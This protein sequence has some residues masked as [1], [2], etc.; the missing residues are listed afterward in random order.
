MIR[1]YMQICWRKWKLI[2]Y[3]KNEGDKRRP[4]RLSTACASKL[5]PNLRPNPLP[6]ALRGRKNP[7]S[8]LHF[9]KSLSPQSLSEGEIHFPPF[10]FLSFSPKPQTQIHTLSKKKPISWIW[11]KL[12]DCPPP[13]PPMHPQNDLRTKIRRELRAFPPGSG[14]PTVGGGVAWGT[15]WRRPTPATSACPWAAPPC[16]S[17]STR[18]WGTTLREPILVQSRWLRALRRSWLHRRIW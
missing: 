11:C 10:P 18:S 2:Y 8:P 6:P 3:N 13:A 14:E 17:S 7:F 16:P 15:R 9:I 5:E 12:Q 4:L 1:S